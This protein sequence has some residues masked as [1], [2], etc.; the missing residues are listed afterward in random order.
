MLPPVIVTS[1]DVVEAVLV[2]AGPFP[3]GVAKETALEQVRQLGEKDNPIF[4]VE[5]PRSIVTVKDCYID[6]FP[7]TN[8][9][10]AAFL[11]ATGHPSPLFWLDRQW[12]DPDQ[13][14]VGISYRDAEAFAKWA[15]K[16]LPTEQ[17]WERAARG[18]DERIWPW[19]NEFRQQHCNSREFGAGRTTAVGMF[20]AGASPVGAQ[21]MA[22]NVWELTSGNWEGQGKAIRGGSYKN[23]AAYCRCTCRWGIDP[24]VKGS[25]WLGFRCVMDLAKARIYGKPVRSQLP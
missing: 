11:E 14:V 20:S 2:P 17:E 10:F 25:T 18:T 4:H 15:G 24:D 1:P 23:G 12:N 3:F 9:R 13:P 5:H 6:R 22:G 21:D 19:G 16:R 8:R 7:V